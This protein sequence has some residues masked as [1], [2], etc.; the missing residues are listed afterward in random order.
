MNL[1]KYSKIENK[2]DNNQWYLLEKLNIKKL[3]ICYDK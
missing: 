2:Y 1:L 3:N